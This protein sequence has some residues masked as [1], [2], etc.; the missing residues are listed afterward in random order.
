M[1]RVVL[2]V[3]AFVFALTMNVVAA[4]KVVDK[5]VDKATDTA[6][7]ACNTRRRGSSAISPPAQTGYAA[8]PP[9]PP[10]LLPPPAPGLNH[11]YQTIPEAVSTIPS[12]EG[13]G[14]VTSVTTMNA[15]WITSTT[16]SVTGQPGTR[17][18]RAACGSLRRSTQTATNVERLKIAE[19]K[20]KK[21]MTVS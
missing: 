3:V 1:K 2:L 13:S 18:G 5:V 21:S 17:N 19:V 10:P 20:A 9:P 15:T 12:S 7:K 14:A 11:R 6:G 16:T 8:P 4:D